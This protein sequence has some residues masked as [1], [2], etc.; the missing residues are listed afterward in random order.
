MNETA[1]SE[2]IPT[3]RNSPQGERSKH[4]Y[5]PVFYLRSWATAPDGK[6]CEFSRPYKTPEGQPEPDIRPI[7][8]KAKRVDPNGTGYI[9]HLYKFHRLK[10]PL[11]T[12]LRMNSFATRITTPLR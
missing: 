1:Q 8:V 4:H 9:E 3:R 5:I 7:P 10:P 6:L 12:T 2:V 11:R